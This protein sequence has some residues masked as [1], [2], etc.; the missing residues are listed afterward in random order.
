V[1]DTKRRRNKMSNMLRS[2]AR[3][4]AKEVMKTKGMSKICGRSSNFF[5]NNWRA[6]AYPTTIKRRK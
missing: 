4:R 5:A 1:I 3:N 2:L 6:Y